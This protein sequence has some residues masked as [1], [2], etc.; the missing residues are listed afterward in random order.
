MADS[1]TTVAVDDFHPFDTDEMPYRHQNVPAEQPG[2]DAPAPGQLAFDFELA[3]PDTGHGID[4]PDL[5]DPAAF[6][7]V[8]TSHAEIVQQ[9]R[10]E[11]TL[12]A[13]S[14]TPEDTGAMLEQPTWS[15]IS[16]GLV[17]EHETTSAEAHEQ[18][19]PS[20]GMPGPTDEQM[21]A[22]SGDSGDEIESSEDAPEKP[23]RRSR[24]SVSVE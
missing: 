15:E 4:S 11:G 8:P 16:A 5:T 19:D 21:D 22:A 1:D 18:R 9:R 2:I 14:D 3:P 12:Q 20:A 17:T 24:A 6:A 10:A 13:D 23:R 7:S